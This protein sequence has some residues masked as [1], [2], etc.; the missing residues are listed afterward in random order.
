MLIG[1]KLRETQSNDCAHFLFNVTSICYSAHIECGSMV[2]S[3][4]ER[5]KTSSGGH[6]VR[7]CLPLAYK[8][9]KHKQDI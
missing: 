6:S 5:C 3:G 7:I 4:T 1:H 9:D 2:K 8:R